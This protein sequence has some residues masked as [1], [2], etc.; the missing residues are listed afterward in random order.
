METTRKHG[1]DLHKEY[2]D[3]IS[4]FKFY[5]EEMEHEKKQIADILNR[6][7]DNEVA[8]AAEQLTNRAD[9]MRDN[10]QKIKDHLR[11]EEQKFAA[12]VHEKPEQYAHIFT[13]EEQ[14]RRDEINY[15]ETQY[16][17]LKS[18]ISHF[19]AKYL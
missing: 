5:E 15:F 12:L 9:I 19:L 16:P 7:T 8:A 14:A 3:W 17:K 4:R 10:L 13:E 1:K 6:Y 2:L 18:D 11:H